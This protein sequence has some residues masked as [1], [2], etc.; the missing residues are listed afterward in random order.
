MFVGFNV[1]FFPMHIVGL[2]GMPRRVYTYPASLGLGT[3]N[4]IET[5]GAFVLGT[6]ILL[7]IINLFRSKKH[8]VLATKN[9]WFADTLEWATD[10]PPEPYSRIHMPVVATRHP[11]WD[12]FDE[13]YD[14]NNERVLSEGRLTYSSTWLTAEPFAIANMPEDTI[15]P[16]LLA[17]A[18]FGF[19]LAL[20]F[21]LIFVALG[22]LGV[23]ILLTA[24]WMWPRS[25]GEEVVP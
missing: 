5:V 10:S 15:S 18:I 20:V 14:P 19:F 12:D 21:Q 13:E 22:A 9:P 1:G 24:Y 25:K 17:L 4:M 2:L 8:G 7:S 23:G 16:L 11:L 6:G 3:I